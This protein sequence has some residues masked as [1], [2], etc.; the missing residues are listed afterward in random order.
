MII[1]RLVN[2]SCLIYL[3]F[4]RKKIQQKNEVNKLTQK[5]KG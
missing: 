4:Q 3:L 2:E 5:E 1:K